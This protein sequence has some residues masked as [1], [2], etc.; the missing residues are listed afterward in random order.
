MMPNT[1]SFVFYYNTNVNLS[2]PLHLLYEASAHEVLHCSL[3]KGTRME[4]NDSSYPDMIKSHP[5]VTDDLHLYDELWL[6]HAIPYFSMI[7]QVLSV[8]AVNFTFS[9]R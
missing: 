9:T 6:Y 5:E 8:N 3:A 2:Q 1:I 4:K 7:N